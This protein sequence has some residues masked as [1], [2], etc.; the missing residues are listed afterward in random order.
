MDFFRSSLLQ[1]TECHSRFWPAFTTGMVWCGVGLR[2][3]GILKFLSSITGF[4]EPETLVAPII[5]DGTHLRS[6]H[7]TGHYINDPTLAVAAGTN[8]TCTHAPG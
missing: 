7:W 2:F 8:L 6:L 1:G 5:T 3:F 4:S